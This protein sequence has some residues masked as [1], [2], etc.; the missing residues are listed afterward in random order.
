[1]ER[2]AVAGELGEELDVAGL[3]DP[4][5]LRALPDLDVHGLIV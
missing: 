4:R 1:V 3:H 5:A 2:V